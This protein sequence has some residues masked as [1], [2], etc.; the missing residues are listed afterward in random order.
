MFFLI[1][2]K[3]KAMKRVL[4]IF[5]LT[6]IMLSFL[7]CK[8]GEND[9]AFSLKSRKAR[10]VG[11]WVLKV[12]TR[13]ETYSG[14][15]VTYS[16]NGSTE[17]FTP[18]I[19]PSTTNIYT[20]KI[21]IYKDGTFVQEINDDGKLLTIK[22]SWEFGR[23]NKD[24]DLKD[25]ETVIFICSSYTEVE[26]GDISSSTYTGTERFDEPYIAQIDKLSSKEL[27]ILI[28]GSSTDVYNDDTQSQTYKGTMTYEKK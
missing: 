2:I 24:L 22:G 8:K 3:L 28:D 7:S 6:T 15:I 19:G 25:K 26:D 9:P 16:Y 18:S 20:Q 13:T 1:N 12:G 5:V 17:I 4:L 11:D 27:V 23:K 21:S 14:G 10:L